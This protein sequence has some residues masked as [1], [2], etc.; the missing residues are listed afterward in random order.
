MDDDYDRA[1]RIDI[2]AEEAVSKKQTEHSQPTSTQL[3][4]NNM[5]K[6]KD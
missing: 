4:I 2:V 1:D 6:N 3:T 5:W